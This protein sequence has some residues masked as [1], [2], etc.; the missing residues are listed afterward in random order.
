LFGKKQKSQ[1]KKKAATLTSKK[2]VDHEMSHGVSLL[3]PWHDGK[4]TSKLGPIW[5][6]KSKAN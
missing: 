5:G 6:A 1:A 4:K 3:S 2:T